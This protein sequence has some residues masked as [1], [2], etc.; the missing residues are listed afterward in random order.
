MNN[1]NKILLGIVLCA[2][3]VVVTIGTSFSYMT[4]N[5]TGDGGLEVINVD[6]GKLVVAYQG[7]T[8]YYEVYGS[9]F[10]DSSIMIGSKSF[11]VTGTNYNNQNLLY[12]NLSV[13]V[14]ENDFEENDIYFVVN[15][16]NEDNG[17][18]LETT[19]TKTRYY[20]SKG[21]DTKVDLGNGFFNN[22]SNEAT[23]TYVIHFFRNDITSNINN[24]K[25]KVNIKF[26][27][28]N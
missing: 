27:K 7:N 3:I 28:V 21:K 6:D 11:S 4:S 24:K 22:N 18:L 20:L 5:L 8:N 16:K 17:S 1:F 23:H 12:Y 15:G 14:E 9:D 25:F 10:D 2:I 13:E 26:N 19:G